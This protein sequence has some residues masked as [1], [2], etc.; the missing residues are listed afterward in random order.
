M[1]DK[2][3]SL[4]TYADRQCLLADNPV[5]LDLKNIEKRIAH[6]NEEQDK[7]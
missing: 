7:K 6:K 3:C 1:Q 2:K 4:F 5:P